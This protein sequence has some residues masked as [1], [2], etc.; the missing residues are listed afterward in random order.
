MLKGTKG[1]VKL[2]D[3]FPFFSRNNVDVYALA[4]FDIFVVVPEHFMI[5]LK[6]VKQFVHVYHVNCLPHLNGF[7]CGINLQKLLI[8][9]KS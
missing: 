1:Q 2:Q 9:V 6:I 8:F 7:F 4:V 3:F 5:S